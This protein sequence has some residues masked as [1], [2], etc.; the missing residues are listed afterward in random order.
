MSRQSPLFLAGEKHRRGAAKNPPFGEPPVKRLTEVLERIPALEPRIEH[1]V[2]ENKPAFRSV[3]T[4][5]T[6]RG[7][8]VILPKAVHD[9]GVEARARLFQPGA[10]A[11]GV[12]VAGSHGAKGVD[13]SGNLRQERFAG[14]VE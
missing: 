14:M 9:H 1:A 11:C 4:E 12:A 7:E 13:G 2:G 3:S 8:P 5:D 10:Q 6:V